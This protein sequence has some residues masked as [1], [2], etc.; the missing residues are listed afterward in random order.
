MRRRLFV[1]LLANILL[2]A[3]AL[4]VDY[5]KIDRSIRKE[6]RYAGKPE[7]ALLLFGHEAGRRVWVVIDAETVFVDR[8]GDG[9]LTAADERLGKIDDDKEIEITD[10]DGKT[11][12]LI[13][14]LRVYRDKDEPPQL[15]ANVDIHGD[16]EYQQYCDAAL[17]ATPREA[18][19]AHFHGPLAI[20]P[21]TISW[22]V[23][24]TVELK[25]GEK[26]VDLYAMVGTMNERHRC[27]VVVVSHKAKECCFADRVRPNVTV[28]FAAKEPGG[29]LVT[30][31]YTLD[32]FC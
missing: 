18:A 32:E 22:K 14:S 11:R 13:A 7:Y 28:E 24:P 25:A 26:P 15:M 1:I 17:G 4:A 19:I 16:L 2:A 5:D 31:E 9:D 8:N 3:P 23:P 20:G 21:R 30:E 12:Y 27:W 29:P 10:P 6:P